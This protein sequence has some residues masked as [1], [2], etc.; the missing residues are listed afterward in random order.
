VSTALTQT[1]LDQVR[2]ELQTSSKISA[3]KLYRKFARCSLVDAKDHVEA[4]IAG[5][6]TPR[7]DSQDKFEVPQMDQILD[8]LQRGKKLEA[9]KLYKEA[10]GCTLFESKAFV[11][12]LM[13]ELEIA[14]SESV[15]RAS[16]CGTAMLL[17][18]LLGSSVLFALS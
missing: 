13:R 15:K 18:F 12:N 4:L 7:F 14:D 11:E 16:G 10:S 6:E 8:A 9:V 5:V 2:K 3:I 17:T 1:Q